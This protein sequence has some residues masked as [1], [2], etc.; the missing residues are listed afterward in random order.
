MLHPQIIINVED[1]N[2][3]HPIVDAKSLKA[4]AYEDTPEGSPLHR[5][6]AFDPDHG[7][8]GSISFSLLDD[9]NGQFWIQE[10]T[11]VLML[12][13]PLDRETVSSY[14]LTVLVSH[15]AKS[16]ACLNLSLLFYRNRN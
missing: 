11:G 5:V 1:V 6:M 16:I 4:A 7:K 13:K 10:S 14:Q 9:I 2:D 3:N 12:G 15:P 8:N